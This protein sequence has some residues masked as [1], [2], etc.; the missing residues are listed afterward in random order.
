MICRRAGWLAA[1]LILAVGTLRADPVDEAVAAQMETRHIPGL[2]LAV[3][4]KGRIVREQGY[5]FRDV[6]RHLPV[7]ADTVFQA[8]SVSKPVAA[9][10]ALR[11]VAD[12]RLHLDE[13]INRVLRS[14]QIP[15]NGFTRRHPVTLR[16]ILGHRAG[17]T[18]QGFSPGYRPGTAVPALPQLLDGQPPANNVP[19][20]VDQAPGAAFRYS[21]G[22]YTVMQQAMDDVTGEAFA[23][24]MARTVLR[25]LGMT[26]STFALEVPVPAS[27]RERLATG[28]TGSKPRP[29][30]GGADLYPAAA[31]AGL[32]TTAGDLARFYLGVQ[33]ALAGDP[34][35]IL[36]PGLARLMVTDQGG[37][38]GLAFFVGGTPARFGH[39]GWHEGFC[40][41]TVA[42]ESGEGVMILMN[43]DPDVDAVADTL[44][45]AVG[46]QYRWPGYPPP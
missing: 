13:D 39:N 12:G 29:L 1:T 38:H 5:G 22:G 23:G 46:R 3:I 11:L 43:S 25:P 34:E 28:Y 32:W 44:V 14:W 4:Q 35:A 2:S 31:A 42:F 20:R 21:G 19:V 7:T 16:L 24:Y 9:L 8:A 30:V 10:G 18:L 17:L 36:A 15:A 26:A 37:S 6:E 41:V 45:R 33:K 27:G 40:A